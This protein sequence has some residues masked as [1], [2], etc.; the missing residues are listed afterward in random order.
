MNRL[1]DAR[2][3]PKHGTLRDV[4]PMTEHV[5]RVGGSGDLIGI[6]VQRQAIEHRV[7]LYGPVLEIGIGHI[8]QLAGVQVT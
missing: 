7:N 6:E 1:A 2:V 4:I 8:K 5:D 3:V